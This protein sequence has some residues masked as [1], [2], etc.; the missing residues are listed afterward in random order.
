[1][2]APTPATLY[3]QSAC[4]LVPSLPKVALS[5]STFFSN[6]GLVTTSLLP[7]L[8][9]YEGDKHV[10]RQWVLSLKCR[11]AFYLFNFKVRSN[12]SLK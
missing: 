7:I 4:T 11:T 2:P 9:R 5:M 12:Q 8:V 3:A 6:S 10:P 1:M